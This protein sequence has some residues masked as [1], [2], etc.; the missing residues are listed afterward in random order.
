MKSGARYL[1]LSLKALAAQ[2]PGGWPN[3]VA[4]GA[5]AGLVG[6]PHEAVEAALRKS[7]KKGLERRASRGTPGSAAITRY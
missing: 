1:P 3:M 7:M 5:L 4:L 2:V 6:L